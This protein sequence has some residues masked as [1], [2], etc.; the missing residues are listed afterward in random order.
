M[1]ASTI[2]GTSMRLLPTLPVL[3]AV[4]LLA[5]A[6]PAGAEGTAPAA[7]PDDN[8]TMAPA[9]GRHLKIDRR[10]GRV[11]ICEETGGEWRCRLVPDDREAYEGE[12]ER[13]EKRIADL[14]S[15]VAKLEADAD[16]IGPNDEKKLDEFMDFTDKAF[17]RFFGLVEDLKRDYE[18]PG[19]I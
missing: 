12:I 15:K 17:R 8:F 9:E 2:G 19:R 7:G 6:P 3:A 1:L 5:A 4:L 16:W 13:L 11:S 10:N 18:E 14:E